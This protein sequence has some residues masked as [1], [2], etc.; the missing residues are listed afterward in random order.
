MTALFPFTPNWRETVQETLSYKTEIITSRSG[1]EQRRA[2]RKSPRRLFEYTVTLFP[3]RYGAFKIFMDRYHQQ[4]MALPDPIRSV[5]TALAVNAGSTAL[6]VGSTASWLV[7]GASVA[8][9]TNG[10]AEQHT[11][12]TVV[13]KAVT[14]TTPTVNPWGRGSKLRPV[15]MGRIVDELSG[16]GLVPAVAEVSMSFQITPTSEVGYVVP[17]AT[18]FFNGRELLTVRPN[19]RDSLTLGFNQNR[20]TL[21]NDF[22]PTASYFPVGFKTRASKATFTGMTFAEVVKLKEIFMRARGMQGELYVPTWE[23]D[24]VAKT[25]L[26]TGQT[27]LRVAGTEVASAYAAS[28]V[29]KALQFQTKDGT[30]GRPVVSISTNAGDS[31]VNLAS[32]TPFDLDKDTVISWLL[33]NRFASDDLVITW[34]NEQVGETSFALQTLEDLAP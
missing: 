10:L 12:Y 9:S 30:G 7:P 27:A 26:A 1:K 34:Q 18:D 24:L 21:D 2:W 17:A 23:P 28:T 31:L 3:E 14:L 8:L 22:G 16:K 13:G 5:K 32:G 25:N 15:V 6:Q 4:E 20:E 11:I 29:H 19:W 33:V